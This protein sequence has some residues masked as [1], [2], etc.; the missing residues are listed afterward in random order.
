MERSR[1]SADSDGSYLYVA[2][3]PATRPA[4]HLTPRAL[5]YHPK[6]LLPLE[7]NQILWQR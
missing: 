4:D 1:Q 5:P 3:T 2:R 7:A 6:A